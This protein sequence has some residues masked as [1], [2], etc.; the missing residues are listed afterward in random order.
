MDPYLRE[1]LIP[2]HQRELRAESRE[3]QRAAGLKRYHPATARFVTWVAD[4]LQSVRRLAGGEAP[5]VGH[6][7]RAG[8]PRANPH[9]HRAPA[10]A[11]QALAL[12]AA[13]ARC[14][15]VHQRSVGP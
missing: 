12:E 15:S 5:H 6:S 4:M 7:L 9:R 8:H 13:G 11:G 14:R 1:V 3:R 2:Q 10:C